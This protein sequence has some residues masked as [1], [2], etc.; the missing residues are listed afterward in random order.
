V[1]GTIFQCGYGAI[2]MEDVAVLEACLEKLCSPG[3]VVRVCEI[4]AH[5]GGTA[6]GIKRYVDS[7]GATLEYWGIEPDKERIQFWWSPGCTVING[8]SIEVFNQVPEDLD[9]VW[10]DGCHCFNHVVLE[11]LH[12]AHKVRNFG[13]LCYH[14]TNPQ[15]QGLD[16]QHYHG[17]NLPEFNVCVNRALESIHWPWGPWELFRDSYPLDQPGCGTRAYRKGK[18]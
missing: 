16:K 9:L 8:D 5:D 14:D 4:G 11:T 13:F 12:Y 10:V 7:H 18:P 2:V 3:A 15:T 6:L 1:S 17:P